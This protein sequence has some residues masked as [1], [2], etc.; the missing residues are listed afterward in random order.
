MDLLA[1]LDGLL[2]EFDR[3]TGRRATSEPQNPEKPQ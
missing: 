3:L 2:D 1:M